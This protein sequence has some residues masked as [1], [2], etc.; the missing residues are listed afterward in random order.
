MVVWSVIILYILN[1]GSGSGCRG[2]GGGCL[3]F[4]SLLNSALKMIMVHLLQM[5]TVFFFPPALFPFLVFFFLFVMTPNRSW[6]SINFNCSMQQVIEYLYI[7]P[8]CCGGWE[9]R[10]NC[11][12]FLSVGMGCLCDGPATTHPL[13]TTNNKLYLLNVFLQEMNVFLTVKRS[14]GISLHLTEWHNWC[15]SFKRF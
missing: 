9:G 10:G 14:T 11:T 8:L 15:I 2:S 1:Y 7:V 4:W 5:L 12:G 13:Y 3:C 6:T